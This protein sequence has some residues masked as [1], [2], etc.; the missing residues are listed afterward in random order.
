MRALIKRRRVNDPY[1]SCTWI[2]YEILDDYVPLNWN[3]VGS[4]IAMLSSCT[5]LCWTIYINGPLINVIS[6]KPVGSLVAITQR[7][8]DQ[9]LHVI[10]L[11]Y[12][13]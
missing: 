13:D 4:R 10:M 3:S 6:L 2:T 9:N 1:L 8:Q 12:C 7:G 5:S 11:K